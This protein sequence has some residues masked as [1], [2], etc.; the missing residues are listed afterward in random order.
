[1]TAVLPEPVGITMIAGSRRSSVKCSAS[2]WTAARCP[3]RSR[4]FA[5]RPNGIVMR[6]W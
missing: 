1:M 2:A 5:L 4:V 6:F 3:R